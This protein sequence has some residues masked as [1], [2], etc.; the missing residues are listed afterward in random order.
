[1]FPNW[2]R[3]RDLPISLISS[4]TSGLLWIDLNS[5]VGEVELEAGSRCAKTTHKGID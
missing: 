1:M 4:K 5:A 2:E 3:R